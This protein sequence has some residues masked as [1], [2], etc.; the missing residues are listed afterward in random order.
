MLLLPSAVNSNLV[1]YVYYINMAG[2]A[3][4]SSITS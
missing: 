4:N 2:S 3:I 1:A